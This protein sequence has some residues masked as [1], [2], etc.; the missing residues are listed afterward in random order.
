MHELSI[1]SCLVE[2]VDERARTIGATRVVA[3]NLA[4]GE[5]SGV[6]EDSLRFCFELLAPGTLA[7]GA[8]LRLRPTW[9]RFRCDPCGTEY[10]PSSHRGDFACPSCGATGAL[11]DDASSVE[12]ESLAVE[13]AAERSD[14]EPLEVET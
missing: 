12:V 13:T 8:E 10:R 7:E 2:R 6:V 3:I 4:V 1:A 9:M 11:L 5:R 14:R